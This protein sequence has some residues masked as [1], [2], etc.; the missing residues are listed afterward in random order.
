M[1]GSRLP[2]KIVQRLR[3][4]AL[5]WDRA[6]QE[7]TGDQMTALLEKAQIFRVTRPAREPVS[8]RLDPRDIF[9]LRRLARR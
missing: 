3:K 1:K 7:E 2:Q 4:E 5:A 8:V 6:G 9:L